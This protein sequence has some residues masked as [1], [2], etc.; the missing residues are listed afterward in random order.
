MKIDVSSCRVILPGE[1]SKTVPRGTVI[2][3][4]DVYEAIKRDLS[5]TR[6][7]VCM[8]DATLGKGVNLSEKDLVV[9]PCKPR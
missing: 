4:C 2:V 5:H 6:S 7:T 9:L 8:T 1:G 3:G